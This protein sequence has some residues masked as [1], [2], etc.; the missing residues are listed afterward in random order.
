MNRIKVHP[1]TAAALDE[2]GLGGNAQAVF[3]HLADNL[4][5]A[6]RPFYGLK[7]CEADIE[8]ELLSER[9]KRRVLAALRDVFEAA[10]TAEAQ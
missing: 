3:L 6:Q 10:N 2:H 8:R 5:D 4:L 7:A 1:L 9:D